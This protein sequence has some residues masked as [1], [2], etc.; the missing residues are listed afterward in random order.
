MTV[1]VEESLLDLAVVA[2]RFH[3]VG[4][5]ILVQVVF[6]VQSQ[7]VRGNL[8]EKAVLFA[9]VEECQ[10]DIDGRK[11]NHVDRLVVDLVAVVDVSEGNGSRKYGRPRVPYDVAGQL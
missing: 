7:A 10:E 1:V 11:H 2:F 3:L 5:V 8:L 4:E 6:L 9:C